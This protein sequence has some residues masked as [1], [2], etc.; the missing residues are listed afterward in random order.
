MALFKFRLP[1]QRGANE[2]PGSGTPTESVEVLRQR[3]RHRLVGAA[4]LVLVGVVGFPLLFDTQPRPI[5]VDIPI[6]IPDKNKVKPLVVPAPVA[7]VRPAASDALTRAEAKTEPKAEV[8]NDSVA[9]AASLGEREQIVRPEK[10]QKKPV[11]GV[12]TEP[13][14]PKKEAE[15]ASRPAP[16]VAA[17][18]APKPAKVT[19]DSEPRE[20]TKPDDGA[21]ARALLDGGTAADKPRAKPSAAAAADARFIVQVGAFADVTKARETRLKVEAAGLKTYTHVAD[22]KDGKRIR[23][24]VGPFDN[25]AD[26]D[27]AAKRIKALSLPAAI[28]TL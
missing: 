16:V 24:R 7:A 25:K 10:E 28:L 20:V 4:V 26:A 17:K 2:A 13:V 8:R 21:K 6:D 14:A 1:G 23:V 11:A 15:K 3:A 22:T 9:T 19:A 5:A 27:K 18:E 12:K